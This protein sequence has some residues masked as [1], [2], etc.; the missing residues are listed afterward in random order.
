M[1]NLKDKT[2]KEILAFS[3]LPFG[4]STIYGIMG[5]ALNLYFTDVLGLSLAM[6]SIVLS[7]TKIWD[8]INDPLMGM[9][10]DKTN[11]KM[12]KCRPYV[13]WM[14]FPVIIVT[15]LLFAPVDLGQKGNFVYAIIAYLLYYTVY[16]ALDI[17]YQGL[18]PLVFPED[19]KRVKAIS[20]S[21]IIGSLGSV[22]PSL[23]FF[24]IA[25]LWGREQ[26]KEGYFFSALIF[27]AIGG[28]PMFFSAFGF[29]EKIKIPP[30][31]E[32]YIDGLKI[33]FKDRKFVCL[34]IAAFFSA[35]VNMGAMFL[36]YFAKWN[37][38]GVIPIDELCAWIKNTIGLDI[39]L[40]SEGLLTPL[41]QV[42]SG[43][44]YMLSM[45]LVPVFL[46][47]MDKK[48]LWIG[49]SVFGIIADILCFVVG[50]WVIPYNTVA[51]AITY[52]I[53]RFFT[54]FPV[55]IMTVL[56]VAMFSDVVDDIEM[57]TGKRLEGTV[58]SFRSLVN[59]IAVAVFNV[60]MLNIVDAY[61]YNAEVMTKITNNLAKPLIESTTQ[62]TIVGGVNYTTL[63]NVIFFMLT[64][65]GA[66]GL[67]L[68]IIPMF[69]YKFDEK[70]QEQ[71]LKAFREEKQRKEIEELNELAQVQEGVN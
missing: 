7:A 15:A 18:T 3:L 30:R 1:V 6:T 32:K 29:K 23:L 47:K 2:T 20:F 24:T 54:N 4:M 33:V 58:F 16:T 14:S 59:K 52:T 60:L 65:F 66:I 10:V 13:F 25:G 53:L 48:T 28:I 21:N 11:T 70:A 44:S 35:I 27:A 31:K 68:Q 34:V 43:I 17:P 64:A 38:A 51:G 36:P 8:A 46:K 37:C 19:K 45:A 71:K 40:T 69:F 26:Q 50:I 42:G 12:G 57:R 41:L 67:I 5:T 62:A 61:G 49:V 55:G 39:Q 9:I 22:L 63:L 56:L